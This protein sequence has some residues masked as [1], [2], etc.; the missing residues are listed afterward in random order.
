[1]RTILFRSSVRYNEFATGFK[2]ID[3]H[4]DH[5]AANWQ[6]FDQNIIQKELTIS[7]GEQIAAG[8]NQKNVKSIRVY[9]RISY[10]RNYDRD[11]TSR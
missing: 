5:L 6:E 9:R 2:E 7:S 11:F 4:G 8:L 3:K 1:M 10:G